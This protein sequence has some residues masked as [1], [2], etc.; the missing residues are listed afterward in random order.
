MKHFLLVTSATGETRMVSIEDVT[1][2]DVL[3]G[4]DIVVMD[5][6]GNPVDVSLRPD[7]ED[8]VVDFKDGPEAVLEGFYSVEEGSK[9]I[10]ISLNPTEPTSENYEFNSQTGNLPNGQAFTLMRYSNTEYVEFVEQLD[11]LDF[12][13]LLGGAGGGLGG[14][15][16]DPGNMAPDALVDEGSGVAGGSAITID[17]LANDIDPLGGGLSIHA[18]AGIGV[19]EGDSVTLPS[20]SVVTVKANG[21]VEVE[22]GESFAGLQEGETQ[23]EIFNYTVRD[24]AGNVATSQVEVT[25]E[26]VND[27]PVA[28]EDQ[29]TTAEDAPVTVDLLANDSDP[30]ADDT[31]AVTAI[32]TPAQ[33]QV[34]L[35]ADNS[36]TFDP[37]GD[38]EH[39][40][41][42]E[43]AT[44]TV[45]YTISD[46]R[47]ETATST[48]T[49]VVEGRNDGPDAVDDAGSTGESAAVVIDARAN[50]TDPDTSDSLVITGVDQ[51]EKGSVTLDSDNRIVFDPGA[52]FDDLDAGESATVTFDYTISD[53][54][55]G[56]DTATVTVTVNGAED[57]TLTNPDTGMTDED[58]G[59][60]I[61]VL[62]NDSDVDASDN[63]LS[64]A[65]VT[66]P[67]DANDGTVGNN[68][69]NLT[70]TPGANFESL[71]VGE[72]A[73]TTFTYT[74]DT[75]ETENVTVTIHG[76]NDGPE[77]ND[78]PATTN[79]D[80]AIAIDVVGNDTDVDASDSLTVVGVDQPSKGSASV[81]SNNHV[82]FDPGADFDDL[83]A[84]E[85]ATVT[86]D[87]TIS[88][89]NGGTDTATVTVTVNGADDATVTNP[90]A[91][92]TNEGAGVTIDVL[93]ND[94]DVDASDDPLS[95]ASVTQPADANDGTVVNNGGN[96]TFTPGVNF[97]SLAVGESATTTFTYTTDT[98]E[99]EDVTVTVHGVNDD[100]I[101]VD[102]ADSTAQGSPVTVSVLANDTDPDSSDDL[103]VTGVTQPTKGSVTNNAGDLT[104]DPGSDFDDLDAG[105]SATVTFDYTISDGNGGTDTATVTLTV[106]GAEDP[107][108]ASPDSGTTNEETA[109]SVDVLAN[110]ND[111]DAGD[112]P[113]SV[114][115]VT[116]PGAGSVTNGGT[117]VTFDPGTDFQGLGSGES[118]TTS[119][120]YTTNTGATQT[121]TMTVHGVNDGP[122][123]VDDPVSTDQDTPITIDAVANDSDADTTDELL[124][125][126]V[127]QPSRG[128]VSIDSGNQLVF[129][130]GADF[131]ELDAGESATVTFDYAI[132]DGSG[133]TDTATVTVTVTGTD[134]ATVTNPDTAKTDEGAGVTIDVLDNDSDAD[135]SD[136]PLS[137]ASVTQPADPNDGTV[138]NNGGDVTFTPGSN[139]DGLALGETAVTTFTYTTDTGETE[140]VT[141]TINGVNEAPSAV[142]DGESVTQNGTTN[143]D[144]L[145]SGDSL[146][147]DSDPDGDDLQV[148]RVDGKVAGGTV[149]LASGAALTLEADG[150][151]DYD[152]DGAFDYLDAGESATDTFTYVV[153]DGNGGTDIATVTVIV[154]G[155]DDAIATDDDL[156][157][158]GENSTVD[159]DVLAN[160]DDPDTSDRPLAVQSA[161]Q[162]AKGSV[163]NNGSDVTFDPGTDFDDL[164]AGESA[165]VT[166]SYTVA[167]QDGAT[168]VETVNVTVTGQNDAAE[169]H[170][171]SVH[172]MEGVGRTVDVVQNDEDVDSDQLTV[173][174]INGVSVS[175][176]QPVSLSSGAIVSVME[177]GEVYFNPNGAHNPLGFGE[178]AVE[179]FT[180]TVEDADGATTTEDVSVVIDGV[181]NPVV[182]S[183]AFQVLSNQLFEIQLD[184]FDESIQYVPVGSPKNFNFNSIAFNA[185]DGLIYGNA[186]GSDAGLGISNGDVFQMDP[187]T[188]NIV[189][190]LGQF[191]NDQGENVPAYAGAINSDINVY[192]MNGPADSNGNTAYALDLD[193]MNLT[194]IGQ[195]PGADFGVDVTTGLLWSID[196]DEAYSLDP[197]SGITTNY[198]H[199]GLQE[200]GVSPAGG[201]FGSMFADGEGNIQVTSNSG[202]GLFRLNT[203]N[204][205]LTRIGDAPATSSNDATGTRSTALPSAQPFVFLD[206]DGST[207]A[208]GAND[209]VRV[210]DPDDGSPVA[211]GDSDTK[212]ADLD[213]NTISSARIVLVNTLSGDTLGIGGPLPGGITGSLSS[214]GG[215]QVVTLNGDA[216]QGDYEAAIRM[217]TFQNDLVGSPPTDPREISVTLTDV[218]GV[219]GNTATSF[220]FIGTGSGVVAPSDTQA[221]D[222]AYA[223]GMVLSEDD[224]D[225]ATG[226]ATFDLLRNDSD[227]PAS[228][229]MISQP[230][231][232]EGT[233]TNNGDGTVT[234]Q[235][236][237]DFHYLSEGET[238]VTSFTYTSDTG[239]TETVTVTIHGVDD[240]LQATPDSGETDAETPLTVDVLAN[241]SDLDS[242][243]QP[244]TLQAVTQPAAGSVSIVGD[245]AVFDPGSDFDDLLVGESATVTFIYTVRNA[246]GVDENETATITINGTANGQ[247]TAGDDSATTAE[248]SSAL[249]DAAANDTDPEG[250]DLLITGVDQ[251]S[252]GSTS[253]DSANRIV[254]DPGSD[255]DHLDDGE[256][257]TV[258]FDYSV[259][260]GNGGTDTATVTV[261]VNGEED[262]TVTAPDT[263]ATNE[264]AA[265]TLDVLANDSDADASDN[266]LAIASVTQPSDSDD[267]M[268]ANN[269]GDLTFTPGSNFQSLATGESATTTFTYTTDTGETENVTVTING[270]N[271]APTV[272]DDIVV[273]TTDIEP[274]TI[275][276]L[277]NDSDVDG[278]LDP[279]SLDLDTGTNGVQDSRTVTGQGVWTTDGTGKV[280]FTPDSGIIDQPDPI[281]Y[282]LTDKDGGTSQ[283]TIDLKYSAADVWFGNDESGSVDSADFDQS[284]NLISGASD[285]MSF[286]TGD[287]AFNAALFTW[288]DS[289]DQQVELSLTADKTQFVND[290]ATYTRN[291]SGGTDI[292]AGIAFGHQQI[293]DSVAAKQ[294]A[295]DPRADVPQVMVILTD[296]QSSQI[297]NDSSLL[298]DAQAA[299]DDGV[300]LVFVA[301]QEAQDDPNAVAKLEQAASLDQ[302]GDPLVVTAAS[303]ADIDAGEIAGLLDA[304]REAAAAGLLPPVVIDMDGDGVEFD[305]R[306]EG[307]EFDADGDGQ[308]EQVAWAGEDDAV[309]VHD[310]N[311]N[312]QID[313]LSEV[314]LARHSDEPHATDL[315][316]LRHFD[317][318]EDLVLDANDEEFESFKVWQDA[319]GDGRV[320]EGE[321]R[322]L[323]EAGIE[324]L[325]L[326]SDEEGYYTAGGDVQVHGEAT[327]HHA[328]GST[329]KLADATFQF[330]ELEDDGSLAVQTDSGD[331]IDVNGGAEDAEPAGEDLLA[332]DGG[333]AET[334]AESAGGEPAG[335]NAAP[336]PT[337]S[338]EDDMAAADAAMS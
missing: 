108:A 123:A 127:D 170:E 101:A 124:I 277:A 68:G 3:P 27:A 181:D 96:L 6:N 220:V 136:N 36:V 172:T 29:F 290:S 94:S 236:G 66:Q 209:A 295:N 125:S 119:F 85:S 274:V 327:V 103:E 62:A 177:D 107:T 151:A 88:D 44:V 337:A 112:N 148:I 297:L 233:V 291:F 311:D 49:F 234:F 286:A 25:I 243:D 99:T 270:V 116:Q 298:S 309:L 324:S 221:A 65:S 34:A 158:T 317:S 193:T 282:S 149:A 185:N 15:G 280:T 91:A 156:A 143:I 46:E 134:D 70:F 11:E 328:D 61:D 55:G 246:D 81:D 83:D 210:Y 267:G 313:D 57:A 60:T 19:V 24:V 5:E 271:D 256:S 293:N 244:L 22:P 92:E 326:T 199:G 305:S 45:S 39:L 129:D 79:E 140:N 131:D 82:V 211:I 303:Y 141:V 7:D 87:Y 86:F 292:G 74:T 240:A 174:Q 214:E 263:G 195:L 227:D 166:F 89:G 191:T 35:H 163:I 262:P 77:A 64:V 288:A 217:I 272:V 111:A 268:V 9:P 152:P 165:T 285:Q 32:G 224:N 13:G 50:D 97:E 52:D 231:E 73:T 248:N 198:T 80:D 332:G 167:N 43:T 160:D 53:G 113:L 266:P 118:A 218:N 315:E 16:G 161:T 219:E 12:A 138:V 144:L 106:N 38:F 130:P 300:I 287:L 226:G 301:I 247:P 56:T 42:G 296:A 182:H 184:P 153:S 90:D 114:A 232:D 207:G 157:S 284:R 213:G 33:G 250:N 276:V 241:D 320:G 289:G 205:T 322:T 212:I 186:Q 28:V 63:P 105:E 171:D 78:D 192:Y 330:D 252:L 269:G 58:A 176:N 245:Q 164:A 41:V 104:F 102:D 294:A 249:I 178:T 76:V 200:D 259:S 283:A 302:N 329:G 154:N 336:M 59:V 93:A 75:G 180:Y 126:G 333:Q 229:A 228:I 278:A 14:G 168:A 69:S 196:D 162:P 312:D 146:S 255:F 230:P 115:S 175:A 179:N 203:D 261:T 51:P 4:D 23:T 331:V 147:A 308:A 54:N 67:A 197:T 338:G 135:A 145:G 204:G 95:V 183:G 223:D 17:L 319:D 72:S 235:P 318:N 279:G 110:D 84:G 215:F 155:S 20:G 37:N 237:D 334:S 139:F 109:V 48:A 253:I 265:L 216:S 150:T 2:L 98:G 121:V 10:T 275:D 194:P 18:I 120:T 310:A 100:P 188:G 254:F 8:L 190:N 133:G 335:G 122:D 132:S 21:R 323:T 1:N 173:T 304:I 316:G 47:G 71:A 258:T 30:D 299:K 202:H 239:E 142:D 169:T 251:P 321:M 117:G 273:S 128:S 40:G 225:P 307:I 242:A 306:E 31:L 264:D 137:I 238:A 325:E 159:I 26:G 187:F 260:D 257:A 208:T 189:G 201:T 314:A 206:A 222:Q 281:T